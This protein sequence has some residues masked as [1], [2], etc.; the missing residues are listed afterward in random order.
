MMSIG[1][2]QWRQMSD[3][4]AM[5]KSVAV[6]QFS[7]VENVEVNLDRMHQLA[8]EAGEAGSRLIVFPEASTINWYA[9]SESIAETAA[10]NSEL[11]ESRL[12]KIAVSE[13]MLVVAGTFVVE[14]GYTRNRMLALDSAGTQVGHYDKVHLYDSFGYRESDKVTAAS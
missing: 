6:G 2:D 13:S 4:L 7:V 8:H 3:E 9:S 1:N 10:A 14:N 11:I 5:V 12:A